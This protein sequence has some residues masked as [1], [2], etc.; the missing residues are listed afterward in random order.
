MGLLALG[1]IVVLYGLFY[2][3]RSEGDDPFQAPGLPEPDEAEDDYFSDVQDAVK[4]GDEALDGQGKLWETSEFDAIKVP[5]VEV[6]HGPIYIADGKVVA[7]G[8]YNPQP[9]ELE[10]LPEPL[11]KLKPLPDPSSNWWDTPSPE[12]QV[13]IDG[14]R[15]ALSVP[16]SDP[17][18][19]APPVPSVESPEAVSD[20][21]EPA[22]APLE[23]TA[24]WSARMLDEHQLWATQQEIAEKQWRTEM[25]LDCE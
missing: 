13:H 3:L 17:E 25:G 8:T 6:R 20:D 11:P 12:L 16:Q 5:S 19:S 14:L 22:Q 9:A 2:Y 1:A 7:A 18:T 24:Q 21:P 10:P 4:E 15:T 23:D